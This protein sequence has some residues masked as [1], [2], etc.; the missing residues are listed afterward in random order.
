M[1]LVMAEAPITQLVGVDREGDE[2]TSRAM[3]TDN[4]STLPSLARG[5]SIQRAATRCPSPRR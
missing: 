5:R 2:V 4:M 3:Q 1:S